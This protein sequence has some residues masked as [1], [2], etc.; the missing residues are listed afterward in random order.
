[1]AMREYF[2]IAWEKACPAQDLTLR[3]L[4]IVEPLAVG[5]HAV[6]RG[7]VTAED[8]IAVIGC[9]AVGLGA[10]AC[11]AARGATAIAIDLDDGK[12]ALATRAGAHHTINSQSESVH[13][14]LMEITGELGPDVVI[15]AVGVPSTYVMAV[16]EAAHTGR[17]VYI[18]WSKEPISF[19]TKLFVHKELDILGSRNYLREFP[20]VIEVLRKKQFPVDSAISLTVPFEDA[21][22]ALRQW[23]ESPQR[24]TK[25]LV[26]LS[27]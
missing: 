7:R 4:S 11:G 18:G 13:D 5:F 9:G 12:L 21:G 16:E 20:A 15:E 14:R 26:N 10:L 24:F 1:G 19:D 25:I 22:D 8:K 23:S 27:A 3:E 6:E 17:V 2:T